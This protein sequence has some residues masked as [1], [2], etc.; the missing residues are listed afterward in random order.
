[1]LSRGTTPSAN[2]VAT[3]LRLA[4]SCLHHRRSA[5]GAFFRRMKARLGTPKAITA[6]AHTLARF[7]DTML[8]YGTAYVAQGMDTYAQRYRTRVVR[9]LIPAR[10]RAGLHAGPNAGGRS[11]LALTRGEQFLGRRH[12]EVG[13][14]VRPKS[15]ALAGRDGTSRSSKRASGVPTRR[16]LMP[17]SQVSAI[18][19]APTRFASPPPGPL[20]TP[21]CMMHSPASLSHR[22]RQGSSPSELSSAA[23]RSYGVGRAASPN[24]IS[25][26]SGRSC[27]MPTPCSF[28]TRIF[29]GSNPRGFAN[30]GQRDVLALV[31]GA[32]WRRCRNK[33]EWWCRTGRTTSSIGATTS[34]LSFGPTQ[35]RDV[36][37]RDRRS[38]TLWEGR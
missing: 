7:V 9:A 6:T 23:S 29:R 38:G 21:G 31:G 8:Q 16:R 14:S 13:L 26:P 12:Q 10:A 1:V 17:S 18:G 11:G 5:L 27:W 33:G 34:G 2:R 3:A 20:P 19:F 15:S 28:P 22:E 37:A 32:D 30:R 35:T 4:A 24:P 25:P 36:N